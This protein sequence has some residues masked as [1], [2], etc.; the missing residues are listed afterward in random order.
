MGHTL[1]R[2]RD[3]D[4]VFEGD[5]RDALKGCDGLTYAMER[6]NGLRNNG[7][8]ERN[9]PA[10][11]QGGSGSVDG[12]LSGAQLVGDDQRRNADYEVTK[13]QPERWDGSPSKAF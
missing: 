7:R 10:E 3:D 5:V 12:D 6:I 2:I 4:L 13:S 8:S 1:G 9:R 11:V